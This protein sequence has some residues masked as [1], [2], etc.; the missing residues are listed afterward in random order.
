MNGQHNS[1]TGEW[2]TPP[3]WIERVRKVLRCIELDPCSSA[4]AN[5][6]VKAERYFTYDHHP[7]RTLWAGT[8]P[9]FIN[10]P[11]TCV[12]GAL[13]KYSE[14]GNNGRCS[15][16][17]PRKFMERA[18]YESRHRDV[19][20][21][22]YSVNQLRQLSKIEVPTD[23]SVSIAIPPNRIAFLDPET[24]EPKKGTNCDS[25]FILFTHKV[26]VGP[27]G[28]FSG[29]FGVEEGCAIYQRRF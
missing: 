16:A 17:L 29:V 21:L 14:C 9:L 12:P 2:Y 3:E 25:A 26:R 22:A 7:L 4:R 28:R 19:M 27:H 10:P 15:C 18:V 8:G 5:E 6:V 1:E 11:G 23:V 20:Y 24:L 13:R